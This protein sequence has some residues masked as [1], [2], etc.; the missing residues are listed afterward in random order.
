MSPS[1]PL[2]RILGLGPWI[3]R[4]AAQDARI[5]VL[6]GAYCAELTRCA[7]PIWRAQ[8]GLEILHPQTSGNVLTWTNGTIE[9]RQTPR[10]GAA[11]SPTYLNSPTRIVDDTNKP[12]RR[13]LDRAAPEF[14]VL[15]ELR[16]E[17]ATDYVMFPLPF[18]DLNR[19]AV[20]SFATVAATGFAEDD[21]A[22]LQVATAMFSPY[23]ERFVLRRAAIDLL[24]TYVGHRTG[25]RI[26]NGRI[27]RGQ[28]ETITAAVWIADL[29]GFTGLID[30]MPREAAIVMLDAW[31][32]SLAAATEAQGGEVLK[33]MGDGMLAIF[34][35]E[36]SSSDACE[37]ALQ[38]AIMAEKSIAELN[39]A[40]S[41]A[42][43]PVL[44]YGFALHLGEVAY[45]NVGG[46]RR[47]DF[48]VIGP[49]VNLA[50]RLEKLTRELAVPLLM[51]E[52]FAQ[53]IDREL[54]PLGSH[55]IRGLGRSEP[56]FGLAPMADLTS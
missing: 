27:E 33:F 38:A 46:Q 17:G 23:A 12:F 39:E 3:A 19:T 52:A 29:R 20:I 9:A 35:V 37:R 36:G 14:P 55:P 47:L 40:R 41:A 26:F 1:A 43:E 22:D 2:Q 16:E 5:D 18:L 45:G 7:L 10:A 31:F 6:F 54:V 11:S 15:D 44:G 24:D 21:I 48:T 28:I 25:E 56:L 53:T 49:A 30:S 4:E 8:L 32:E 42:G 13:R 34:P 50:A 51:S